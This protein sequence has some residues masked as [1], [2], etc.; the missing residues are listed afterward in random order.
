[1]TRVL[2]MIETPGT[3][4]AERVLVDIA[5]SLPSPFESV[6]AILVDGWTVQELRATGI[7][8][9]ILPLQRSFDYGWPSRLARFIQ[10]NR[11]DIVHAH[12]FTSAV[13]AAFGA[14]LASVPIVSTIHGKNYWPERLYRRAALRIAIEMSAAFVAVSFDLARF[15]SATVP[16]PERK[17]TVVRNGIDLTK[18]FPDV[19]SAARA[20]AELG[21][22]PSDVVILCVGALDPVKGQSI[23]V[24]VAC[25]LRGRVAPF[26]IWIV[27]EGPLRSELQS[28]IDK[29][30]LGDCVRLLGWRTDV[31]TLLSSAN[32]SVLPSFS[33]GMPLAV[34]ESMACGTPIVASRV[35]GVGELIVDGTHG[36][37]VRA[38]DV[39]ALTAAVSRLVT[40]H[41]LG[42]RLATAGR[43]RAAKEFSLTGMTDRYA[44]LYRAALD[45]AGRRSLVSAPVNQ[46]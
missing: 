32:L 7:P 21:A 46:P 39:Q 19:S 31:A 36:L 9:H 14:A 11:I 5:R 22:A 26:K 12:E 25:G 30:N 16:V 35:G 8:C 4:G 38:G 17:L 2:H 3:G 13:Y 23:L 10:T 6:G 42:S 34:M 1:M 20:R 28:R 18:F 43:D 29:E 24:D 41:A 15:V 44:E 27:G 33:E 40:D 37:L 45:S